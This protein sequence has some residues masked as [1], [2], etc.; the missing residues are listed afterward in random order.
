VKNERKNFSFFNKMRIHIALIINSPNSVYG[1]SVLCVVTWLVTL[2]GDIREIDS[3][4]I[5]AVRAG[6]VEHALS[7]RTGMGVPSCPRPRRLNYC[8]CSVEYNL[9]DAGGSRCR[10]M[11]RRLVRVHGRTFQLPSLSFHA[12]AA[13]AIANLRNMLWSS[14]PLVSC[15]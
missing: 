7:C 5:D 10:C 13:C 6:L 9:S 3:D 1:E 2:F 4:P 15:A 11:L 12:L 14:R 8:R